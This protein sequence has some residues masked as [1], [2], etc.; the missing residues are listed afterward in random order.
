M[1]ISDIDLPAP[2]IQFYQD[3]GITELYPPQAS[4]I[5]AGL[6]SS[7]NIVAAI[8]TASGKT[9]LAEFAMLKSILDE[10]RRGKAL[11]IVP[12]RALAS[13][14][15]DR[16]RGFER[17]KKND[18]RGI[19]TGI[20]TGDFDSSDEWLG[21]FDIIVA[22]SEKVDSLLR[23]ASRWM[24][25]ITVI[26]ADEIHLIDSPDRGPTLEI[27]LAKLMRMNPGMRIIA[28]SATIGNANE[29]AKWLNAELVVSDWRPIELK[30]GVFFGSAINFV[31]SQREVKETH[32]D[33]AISLVIDTLTEGGQTLV[34]ESSRKNAEG[35]ASRAGTAVSPLI[36]GETKKKL[37]ELAAEIRESSEVDTAKKLALCEPEV[38]ELL[39]PMPVLHFK[40][41]QRRAKPPQNI[42]ECPC[43]Y[44]P[45]REGTIGRDSFMLKVDLKSGD[46]A[47]EFWVKRGAALLMADAH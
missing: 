23:N 15:F 18:G 31:N 14:K 28:L 39:C 5:E 35:L 27:V 11:Y 32:R 19:S 46:F 45:R 34:F 13:E 33:S 8:P 42:Y 41:I 21:N 29:I 40:P 24:E 2:V 25:E 7:K 12:L 6:L 38:M 1:K 22:T 43:Y 16:F 36:P 26:V 30:E 9:L 4:A 20:A 47:A 10:D 17:I 44:Y 3:S 37:K